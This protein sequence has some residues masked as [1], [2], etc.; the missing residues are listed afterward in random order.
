VVERCLHDGLR[1]YLLHWERPGVE[2]ESYGLA[3]YAD[4]L[5]LACLDAIAAET[6]QDR[7]FLAGHSLGGTLAAIFAALQHVGALV[8]RRAH[9][10]LWPEIVR[11]VHAH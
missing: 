10:E 7:I 4:Q 3:E 11:W 2:E 8:G 5:L 9:R 6:G 1:T